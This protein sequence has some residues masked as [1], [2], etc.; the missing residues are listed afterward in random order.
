MVKPTVIITDYVPGDTKCK[1]E[2]SVYNEM[3]IYVNKTFLE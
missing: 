2:I 1:N 3:L